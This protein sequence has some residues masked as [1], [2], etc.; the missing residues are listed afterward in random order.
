MER[1]TREE[2]LKFATLMHAGIP[3]EEAIWFFFLDLSHSPEDLAKLRVEHDR[4]L[5]SKAVK[6]AIREVRGWDWE[7][8]TL[9]EMVKFAVDKTYREMAYFLHS[10]NYA[11]LAAADRQKADTCRQALEAKLAGTAGK[12]TDLAQFTEAVLKGTLKIPALP[13]PVVKLN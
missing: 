13:A 7:H 12:T 6:D 3:S 2:A 1:P 11:S 8:L 10:R 4:W 5:R 9:D